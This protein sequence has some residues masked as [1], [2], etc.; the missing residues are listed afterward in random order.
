MLSCDRLVYDCVLTAPVLTLEQKF[1]YSPG[2][3]TEQDDAKVL[4]EAFKVQGISSFLLLFESIGRGVR[5]HMTIVAQISLYII[6]TI[7]YLCC[8]CLLPMYA[9]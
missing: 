9:F 4:A 7:Y 5:S 2:Q 8:Y 6:K 3:A 1:K